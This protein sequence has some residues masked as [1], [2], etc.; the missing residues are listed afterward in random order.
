MINERYMVTGERLDKQGREKGYKV[1]GEER[2]YIV[3]EPVKNDNVAHTH[4]PRVYSLTLGRRD[5]ER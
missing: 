4:T 1:Q 5:C 3:T 2:T